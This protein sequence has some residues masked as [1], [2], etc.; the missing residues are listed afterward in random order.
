MCVREWRRT[1]A[2]GRLVPQKLE[3]HVAAAAELMVVVVV[4]Q[5]AKGGLPVIIV[6]FVIMIMMMMI[7]IIMI[8]VVGIA[9]PASPLPSFPSSLSSSMKIVA[10]ALCAC[11]TACRIDAARA[12]LKR[13]GGPLVSTGMGEPGPF[14]VRN[15]KRLLKI[16][17][18]VSMA[19][20]S[21]VC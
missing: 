12:M 11:C 19:P 16:E 5:M 21:R 20:P 2:A 4:V 3:L 13:A 17:E 15:N 8:A 18:P 10:C 1:S 14:L 6:V 7:F 9:V